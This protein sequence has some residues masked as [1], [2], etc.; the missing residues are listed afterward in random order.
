MYSFKRAKIQGQ[1]LSRLGPVMIKFQ[2]RWTS[3]G[4]YT[5]LPRPEKE[6]KKYSN[7]GDYISTRVLSFCL[8]LEWVN[9]LNVCRYYDFN[10][11][12]Y[13]E[14]RV[15]SFLILLKPLWL[16]HTNTTIHP[17]K[18]SQLQNKCTTNKGN[19]KIK[20][21]LMSSLSY[22]GHR[23][24]NCLPREVRDFTG[25]S[26]DKFKSWLDKVLSQ[27]PDEPPAPGYTKHCTAA[28][29]SIQDQMYTKHTNADFR[30][31]GGAPRL[32][33]IDLLT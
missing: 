18:G 33:G 9:N 28:T 31:I 17:E 20:S 10:Y 8:C 3:Y 29:N 16:T 30:S 25:C 11:W 27:F 32:S 4:H 2:A 14:L 13:G 7:D 22:K 5:W 19:C 26:V 21:L 24:F 6:E 12:Q 15:F 23:I 1:A